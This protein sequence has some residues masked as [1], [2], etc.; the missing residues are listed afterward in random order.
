M[1]IDLTLT[2]NV[3]I[4]HTRYL[5]SIVVLVADCPDGEGFVQKYTG[6]L[7][8][9]QWESLLPLFLY[10]DTENRVYR[11]YNI[12]ADLNPRIK[13]L[14]Y[15]RAHGRDAPKR[16]VNIGVQLAP[17]NRLTIEVERNDPA[18]ERGNH[19]MEL[20]SDFIPNLMPPHITWQSLGK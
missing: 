6:G 1:L 3:R 17:I 18:R 4:E 14:S 20:T 7:F 12:Q 15:G 19:T 16:I 11:G 9:G 13:A 5:G 10:T 2:S 8:S